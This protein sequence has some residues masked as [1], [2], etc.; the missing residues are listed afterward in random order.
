[1]TPLSE[2]G[3]AILERLPE[4]RFATS[5]S[6]GAEIVRHEERCLGCGACVR[7]CPTGATQRGTTLD[8][9]Q[10]LAAPAGSGRGA[11]GAALRRLARHAPTDPIEVPER[12]T[13]YRSVVY[14]ATKC[15]GCG[16]CA[17]ACPVQAIDAL[18]PRGA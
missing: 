11:L 12:V 9:N 3:R 5:G 17:R 6:V 15:L 2:Q 4:G 16:A 14:D 8:V 10:L 1:V 7:R 13:V 18:P